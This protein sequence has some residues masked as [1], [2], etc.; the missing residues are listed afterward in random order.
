MAFRSIAASLA[1]SAA[2]CFLFTGSAY[3]GFDWGGD[4][5][6][7]SGAFTEYVP[8][9]Q[10]ITLG[11]IPT[12]KANVV[13]S[14]DS[15]KDVDVQL[16]DAL[17]GVEIISWPNGLLNGESEEC[18]FYEG[19]QYC[20]SGYNGDQSWAG[21]GN[22]WI[23][24]DGTTNRPLIMRVYGY[25]AGHSR[26]D[27]SWE[28]S[29]SCSEAGD[30]AFAQWVPYY[31]N[32]EVGDIPAGKV[33]VVIDLVAEGGKDVDIQLWD[34]NV[35]LVMWPDGLL[36]GHDYQE[37]SYDGLTITYSGYNGIDGDWGHE[38]IEIFGELSST[39]TMDAFGYQEGFA[40]VVYSW[41]F[42]VGEPC[43]GYS[44]L[45]CEVGLE[46]KDVYWGMSYP[47]GTCHTPAWC[48]S[49]ATAADDCSNLYSPGGPGFWG[50]AANE[51]VWNSSW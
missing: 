48:L 24:V 22:E 32:I 3:A 39:L 23:S 41:G 19:R 26:V 4:C 43:G 5:S 9:D 20:Y 25:E 2:L 1:L 30:G 16:I 44:D 29:S 8:H 34:G 42:G 12:G 31:A 14:L 27:Y 13:I 45:S 46:C 50:C 40:D 35:P 36:S 10:I 11:D 18:T 37:L 28:G 51:C 17:T 7:G 47:E 6:S 33:N 49:N 38:R 15:D 21:L